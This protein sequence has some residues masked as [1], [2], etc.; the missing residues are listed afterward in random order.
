MDEYFGEKDEYLS[1]LTELS[2]WIRE[3]APDKEIRVWASLSEMAEDL[4]TVPKD[5]QMQVW[6]TSWADPEEMYE[7]GFPILNSL[8]SSLYLIPGGGYDW[9]DRTF[10]EE[11]WQP[12]IFRTAERTWIL[13]AWSERMLG[14]C[15]MMWN[16]WWR[17]GR[18][19]DL[20]RGS[21]RAVSG[22]AAR[23]LPETLGGRLKKCAGWHILRSEQKTIR[24]GGNDEI[25]I[26]GSER[27]FTWH[28]A[29]KI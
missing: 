22:S 2:S 16:D 12:N 17:R 5:L 29:L 8:S 9:M 18:E 25:Q 28:R 24:H 3:T 21:V 13:P 20:G 10:L 27:S 6:D 11:E 23:Y 1:Y 4:S 15:Y 7:A 14:A 26:D 19:R